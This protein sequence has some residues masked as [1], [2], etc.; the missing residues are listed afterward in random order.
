MNLVQLLSTH[1]SLS[2]SVESGA[3]VKCE[4]P[5]RTQGLI[6]SVRT[7]FPRLSLGP[8]TVFRVRRHVPLQLIKQAAFRTRRGCLFYRDSLLRKWGF[9]RLL[10]VNSTPRDREKKARVPD[11]FK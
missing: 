2:L 9:A 11:L 8:S 1:E 4:R 5:S 3:P 6:A 10:C 7:R